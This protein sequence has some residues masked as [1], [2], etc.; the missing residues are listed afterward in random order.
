MAGDA[1]PQAAHYST[2]GSLH[3]TRPSHH[4]LQHNEVNARQPGSL[5]DEGGRL[6]SQQLVGSPGQ[7]HSFAAAT[8]NK[9]PR[10]FNPGACLTPTILMK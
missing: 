7:D 4:T 6:G 9:V 10:S 2:N 5:D 3:R 8:T 1:E